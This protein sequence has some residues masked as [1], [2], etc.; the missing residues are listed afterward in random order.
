VFTVNS[1]YLFLIN[2]GVIYPVHHFI[3]CLKITEDKG[4]KNTDLRANARVAFQPQKRMSHS[5]KCDARVMFYAKRDGRDLDANLSSIASQ[6]QREPPS[7]AFQLKCE[8]ANIAFQLQ[9][10][11]TSSVFQSRREPASYASN[12]RARSTSSE[13]P[14]FCCN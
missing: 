11:P 14:A 10:E 6:F 12:N 7:S 9:G 1:H 4:L 5:K 8:P 2:S 13:R 3:G